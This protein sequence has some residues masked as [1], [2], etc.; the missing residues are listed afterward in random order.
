[1][2]IFVLDEDP[3]KAA[4]YHC[5]KHVCK[6]I[7]ES[8][9][10][11]CT[12]HWI[13]LEKQIKK[14]IPNVANKRIVRSGKTYKVER[15]PVRVKDRVAFVREHADSD[16]IPPYKMTHVKHP[17]TVWTGVNYSNYTWHLQLGRA[18]CNEYTKRYE[19]VHKT[20]AVIEWLESNVPPGIPVESRTP[21]AVA[22]KNDEIRV[23]DRSTMMACNSK[24]LS[25][26]TKE[27]VRAMGTKSACVVNESGEY[28]SNFP[29]LAIANAPEPKYREYFVYYDV[30]A[31]YRNYYIKEKSRFAKWEPRTNIPDWYKEG[32][33]GKS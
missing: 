16:R 3:V 18:L 17:C 31:S 19:K 12:T 26:R 25:G 20:E 22:I 15:D 14:N 9:Q 10:M 2:N 13:Y 6:M 7:L 24:S 32:L 5:N 30:V 21:F 27:M 11:L 4:E 28:I 8:A 1:M 33:N 23:I 29:S